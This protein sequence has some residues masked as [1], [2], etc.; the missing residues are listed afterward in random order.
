MTAF[1]AFAPAGLS[2]SDFD[3]SYRLPSL[4]QLEKEAAG[5][6]VANAALL[7]REYR[8]L[9]RICRAI[10]NVS[11]AC[12]YAAMQGVAIRAMRRAASQHN[13]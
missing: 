6:D 10:G 9:A 3:A 8:E 7:L 12:K 11:G 4:A 13:N 2:F 1:Y 5:E